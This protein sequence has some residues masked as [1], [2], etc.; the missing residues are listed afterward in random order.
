MSSKTIHKF[1]KFR[2]KDLKG[3]QGKF[4]NLNS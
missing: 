2:N 4:K 1:S 3:N